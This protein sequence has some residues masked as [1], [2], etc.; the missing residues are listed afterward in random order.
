[1]VDNK[2]NMLSLQ[3]PP[4]Q[5]C[6]DNR[7]GKDAIVHKS[8]P[9][10]P[11]EQKDIRAWAY[12]HSLGQQ[13]AAFDFQMSTCGEGK[14]CITSSDTPTPN[15]PSR[16]PSTRASTQATRKLEHSL[17]GDTTTSNKECSTILLTF[18]PWVPYS[19][20]EL[21]QKCL[22][23]VAAMG[24]SFRFQGHWG[25]AKVALKQ[26]DVSSRDG[27]DVFQ[28]ETPPY[29]RLADAWGKFVPTPLFCSESPA[30][31]VQFL[32]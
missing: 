7:K 20:L 32:A 4:E 5:T 6:P 27:L 24:Q 25:K 1:M 17:T 31:G 23:K 9:Y 30:G 28:R 18:L 19:K 2:S 3:L 15:Q 29:A 16:C 11:G 13:H 14:W 8:D 26:L 12:V 22:L 21:I 10:F